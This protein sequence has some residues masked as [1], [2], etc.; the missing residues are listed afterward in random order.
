[1][2]ERR[3]CTESI[4][5]LR[6]QA[7]A[8]VCTAFFMG[9]LD[10]TS[11]YAALPSIGSDL[12]LGPGALQ[13]VVTGYALT[14]G[15]FLLIGGR[16]ADLFGR[17][18]VFLSGVAL[19]AVASLLCGLAG[20][21]P[22]LIGARLAQGL[23]AAVMTPAGLA[24]LTAT[25]REGPE[26][27]RALAIWGG[28]GGIG[29]SAGL[30]IGG[31][32]TD[33]LGWPWI[34]WTNVPVCL[35]V[36]ILARHVV[37]EGRQTR[38]G[39]LDIGAALTLT[40]ALFALVAAIVTAPAAGWLPAVGLGLL[41]FGLLGG[42]TVIERRAA[43]PLVPL[44]LLT[45]RTLLGGNLV[46]FIAGIA[47]DGLL[48]LVTLYTQQVLGYSATRFGLTM[49]V[50]T[51]TSVA[52]VLAGS[53]LVTRFGPGAVAAGGTALIALGCAILTRISPQ[54]SFIDDL[55]LGLLVFGPGMGAAF[56]AAQIAALSDVGQADAGLASGV[57]ETSFAFGTAVGVAISA[58]VVAAHLETLAGTDMPA[59]VALT[60]AIRRALIVCASC[61][62]AGTV[63]AVAVLGVWRR[64]DHDSAAGLAQ[65]SA[66]SARPSG[67]Q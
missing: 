8:V 38:R 63:V 10:S 17:R 43:A 33:L 42:F 67:P 27:H 3:V 28:L 39:P 29:A 34:F 66:D 21:G 64:P 6:W 54:G 59:E 23:G 5:P 47:V 22:I 12:G 49:A 13:W 2:H 65:T 61:A 57:E 11:V 60:E 9:V 15:G 48:L 24:I 16:A 25:F 56:V 32:L 55:L 18:R 40:A 45:T 31:P 50:M 14:I 36:L 4:D 41:G 26:R 46:I 58:A 51:L 1:M 53:R 20:S 52:G 7:L 35:L 44:R 62:V 30:F 19:F 37:R